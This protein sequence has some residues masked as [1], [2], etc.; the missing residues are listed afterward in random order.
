[1]YLNVNASNPVPQ[2]KNC[3]ISL[4]SFVTVHKNPHQGKVR[5]LCCFAA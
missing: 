5:R 3:F 4:Y 1:M 2:L